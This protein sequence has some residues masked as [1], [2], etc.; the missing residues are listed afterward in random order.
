M[1]YVTF[2][3]SILVSLPVAAQ[4]HQPV[5]WRTSALSVDG[6]SATVLFEAHIEHGWHIYSQHLSIADGPMPTQFTF[7]KSD[8]YVLAGHTIEG[9]PSSRQEPIYANQTLSYFSGTASFKQKIAIRA[10]RDFTIAAS[11]TYMVCSDSLCLP[12]ETE[13]FVIDVKRPSVKADRLSGSWLI[14]IGGFAGGLLA[15][16]TPCV[17]SMLPLTV[18]FF[19]KQSKTKTAGIRNAILYALSIMVI[20][21]ALGLAITLLFGPD[22]LNALASSGVVNLIFFTLFVAFAL[23]FFGA[24]EIILPARWTNASDRASDKGGILGIFFMAFTLALVSFSCTGPIIGSLLVQAAVNG[25]VAGPALGMFGFSLALAL[26]FAL[27]AAFPGWL[28]SLPKSGSWLNSIKVVLGFIELA[29]ALKFLSAVDL[30]YHL[31]FLKRE[32]FIALWIAIFSLLGFYLL[33]K[34]RL[35]HDGEP[36]HTSITGLIL[37]ILTFAFV[38]YLIPGLWGAPLKIIS[39]FPPPSFYTEGWPQSGAQPLAQTS[40][41]SMSDKD[42]IH[43]PHNLNCFHDYDQGLAYAKKVNKPIMLDFTGWSCVN[44]RKMEDNV[45]SDPTVLGIIN[46]DYVLISLYVDDKTE[47]PEAEKYISPVT[48]KNIKTVGNKWSDFETQHF[49]T[50]SQPYY[51]LTDHEGNLLNTPRAYDLDLTGYIN[52][53][54]EGIQKFNDK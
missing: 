48:R 4:V 30:A 20:Y 49:K 39:G 24:F 18:S 36:R 9:E 27:F 15:L 31:G 40:P 5:T 23:S 35:P 22:A 21:I 19:T 52:F 2:L 10:D 37:A 45:W 17:F 8:D 54:Q 7:Q 53:L 47:L 42:E 51:A 29:L 38:I 12:P 33:G 25:D 13:D 1:K 46:Q 6:D 44:C 26:P 16:L 50:N 3:I 41:E 43:C 28:N 34:L 11:V 32:L 14:F